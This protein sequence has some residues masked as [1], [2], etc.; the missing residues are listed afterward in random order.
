GVQT[1]ALP[2]YNSTV[3]VPLIIKPPAGSGIRPDRISSPVETAALA[4]TLLRS[5]GIKDEMEKQF[6]SPS[7]LDRK[8][9]DEEP[10]YSETFY[11]F[12]SFGWSPLHSLVASRYR[13]I[14]APTPELYDET[15]DPAEKNNL[16][17]QQTATAA[18]LKDK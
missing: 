11:P 18:A 2:I 13:Y 17:S 3:R 4:P 9:A 16:A 6:H 14:D 5:T 1:C 10:A 15:S 7:L 8:S 12:S